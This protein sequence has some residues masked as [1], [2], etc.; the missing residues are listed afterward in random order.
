MPARSQIWRGEGDRGGEPAARSTGGCKQDACTTFWSAA[1]PINLKTEMAEGES[2]AVIGSTWLPA[3]RVASSYR[4]NRCEPGSLVEPS[5]TP[6]SS[7]SISVSVSRIKSGADRRAEAL[8]DRR[9]QSASLGAVEPG[10]EHEDVP[11]VEVPVAGAGEV[12]LPFLADGGGVEVA[13]A[14]EAGFAEEV[15]GPVAEGAS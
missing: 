9:S 14:F 8:R 1:L 5:T 15:F 3:S 4:C 13:F 10:L 2:A 11:E 7:L 12:F 6:S